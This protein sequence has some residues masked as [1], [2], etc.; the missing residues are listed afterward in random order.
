MSRSPH[1]FCVS[2]RDTKLAI[3][4]SRN[5]TD[6]EEFGIRLYEA[7]HAWNLEVKDLTIISGG[8]RGADTLAERFARQHYLPTRIF[9]ADWSKGRGAGIIRNRDII[10]S[11]EY[12]LAFPSRRNSPGTMNSIGLARK[13]EKKLVIVWVD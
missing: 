6:E 11:A 7:L 2:V 13:K 8:A 1:L 5:F 10:A 4:G 3:V 9:H 12:V